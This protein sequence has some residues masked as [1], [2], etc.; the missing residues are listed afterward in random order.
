MIAK[1]SFAETENTFRKVTD[2][3]SINVRR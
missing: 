2:K 3:I 1:T